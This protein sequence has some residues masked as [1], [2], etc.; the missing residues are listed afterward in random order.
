MNQERSRV[1]R[2]SMGAGSNLHTVVTPQ[3]ARV[4]HLTTGWIALLSTLFLLGY[5]VGTLFGGP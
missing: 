5:A 3:I 1:A 2:I 4:F